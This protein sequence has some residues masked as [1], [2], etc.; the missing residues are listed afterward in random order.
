MRKEDGAAAGPGRQAFK[1][2]RHSAHAAGTPPSGFGLRLGLVILESHHL[3]PSF[4]KFDTQLGEHA[5]LASVHCDK[6]KDKAIVFLT[7]T[8]NAAH[9]LFEPYRIPRNIVIYDDI[10]AVKV[11][12]LRQHLSRH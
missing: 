5:P 7:V 10:G 8:M 4:L 2:L 9:A 12:P 6:V 3:A 11:D 1:A